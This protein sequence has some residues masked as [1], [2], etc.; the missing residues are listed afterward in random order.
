M[1][2]PAPH[3]SISR[4]AAQPSAAAAAMT[5]AVDSLHNRTKLLLYNLT[6]SITQLPQYL[7]MNSLLSV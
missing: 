5:E 1:Q 2:F 6:P 7:K 4:P 3:P